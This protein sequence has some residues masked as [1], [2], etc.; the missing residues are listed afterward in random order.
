MT[1]SLDLRKRVISYVSS[2]GSKA[3]ASSR[4]NVSLRT[5]YYWFRRSDL[6]PKPPGS[7]HRKI[8]KASLIKHV[9]Q[10]PDMLLSERAAYFGV[11]ES[12]MSRAL[13]KMNIRKKKNADT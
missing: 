10:V 7:R 1:Y 11:H 13:S 9:K 6:T 3:E 12:S 2:G 8:D 4:F 5:I